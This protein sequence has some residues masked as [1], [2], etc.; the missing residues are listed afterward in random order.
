MLLGPI[1]LLI[2]VPTLRMMFIRD[3][4]RQVSSFDPI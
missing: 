3:D 1:L 2:V 4:E